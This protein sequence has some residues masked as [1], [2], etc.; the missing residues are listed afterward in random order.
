ME[1]KKRVIPVL[2]AMIVAVNAITGTASAHPY[3][4]WNG[5]YI[6]QDGVDILLRISTSAQTDLLNWTDVYSAGFSW[7]NISKNVNIRMAYSIQG[8][9]PLPDEMLVVGKDI[10]R[11][12]AITIPYGSDGYPL[13]KDGGYDNDANW[14]Y[15]E[16]TMNTDSGIFNRASDPTAAARKTFVHEVGHALKLCHPKQGTNIDRHTINGLPKAIMNQGYPGEQNGA[17]SGTITAHDKSCL[18]TKWG[19]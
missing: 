5:T 14:A 13:M 15:S 6:G 1:F 18:F 9:P 11:Y 3:D 4:Y 8:M 17:T 12:Y 19:Y 10:D 2:A 16:I 7:N